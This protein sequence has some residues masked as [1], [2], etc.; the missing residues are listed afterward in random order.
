[1]SLIG[2]TTGKP[3]AGDLIKDGSDASFIADVVEASKTQPVI[4]KSPPPKSQPPAG[5]TA[6]SQPKS[7]QLIARPSN[8]ALY[9]SVNYISGIHADGE[10]QLLIDLS[11]PSAFLPEDLSLPLQRDGNS[12]GTGPYRLVTRE[13]KE[14]VLESSN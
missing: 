7:Q 3:P 11:E 10:R 13:K 4:A 1:M 8:R 5:G 12:V 2:E 9:P 14:I 6:A